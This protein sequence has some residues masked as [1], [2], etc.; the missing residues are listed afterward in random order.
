MGNMAIVAVLSAAVGA[1]T[2]VQ[3]MARLIREL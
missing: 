2:A 3:G 1:G